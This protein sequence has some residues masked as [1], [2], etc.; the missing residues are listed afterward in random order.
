MRKISNV[1]GM[2]L[3]VASSSAL[4]MAESSHNVAPE[5]DVASAGSAIALVS[6][7]V[8]LFRARRAK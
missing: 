2:L 6:G 1:L 5:I 8:L 7:M 3:L 4:A